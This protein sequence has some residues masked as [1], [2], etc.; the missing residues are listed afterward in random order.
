LCRLQAIP[1]E[2]HDLEVFSKARATALPPHR[3]YDC[4]IDLHPGTTP[5][6]GL[7]YSL[8]GPETKAMEDYIEDSLATGAARP[9]ASPADAGF[10]FVEEGQHPASVH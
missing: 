4:A 8:S 10:F 9:S 6:R 1:S 5:P 7:L 2:Y 3:P